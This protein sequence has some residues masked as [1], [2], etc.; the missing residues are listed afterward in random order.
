MNVPAIIAL[1]LAILCGFGSLCLAWSLHSFQK[2]SKTTVGQVVGSQG[3]RALVK[4]RHEKRVITVPAASFDSSPMSIGRK[5]T[6]KYL[7]TGENPQRWDVR[8]IGKAGYGQRRIKKC[9]F[10]LAC[11]T[12]SLGIAM[13]F[14][15]IYL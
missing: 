6:L 3:K 14:F 2:S 5:V 7:A 12:L 15:L 10:G 9:A 8:I 1:I 11:G 13:T 4:F